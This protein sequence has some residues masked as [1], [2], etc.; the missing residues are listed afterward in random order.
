ME[1]VDYPL[2]KEEEETSDMNPCVLITTLAAAFLPFHDSQ[3]CQEILR[4]QYFRSKL[5]VSCTFERLI[6]IPVEFSHFMNH[7]FAKKCCNFYPG[8]PYFSKVNDN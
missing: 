2:S 6:R 8:I 4:F 5:V 7:K 3:H 1:I